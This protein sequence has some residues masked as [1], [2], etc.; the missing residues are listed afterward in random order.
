MLLSLLPGDWE[1]V[2][3]APILDESAVGTMI[4]YRWSIGWCAGE[5]WQMYSSGKYNV[6][7]CYPEDDQLYDHMLSD[8]Q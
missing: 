8:I 3:V 1:R 6:E 4:A 5:I 2:A 7:V